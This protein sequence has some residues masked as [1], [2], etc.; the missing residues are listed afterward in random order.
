[1]T[2]PFM[3]HLDSQLREENSGPH[4]GRISELAG[5]EVTRGGMT[6]NSYRRIGFAYPQTGQRIKPAI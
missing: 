6:P 1:V 5:L 2:Q 4:V 3:S